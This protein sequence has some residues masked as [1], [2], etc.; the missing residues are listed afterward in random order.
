MALDYARQVCDGEQA[1][2]HYVRIACETFRQDYARAISGEGPWDF[3]ADLV[4][5]AAAFAQALPNIKGPLAGQPL[6]LM[7]WQAL[8][9]AAV[10]GLVERDTDTRRYRQAVVFVGKGNGKTAM[11]A[12]IAL[13]LTFADGEGGAEGYA[14]ATTRD[15]KRGSCSMPHSTCCARRRGLPGGWVSRSQPIPSTLPGPPAG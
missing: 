5:D 13:Y 9:F 3:R 2:C 12:P 7:P 6:Q 8:L 4:D 10:F 15:P 1:V 14:A 11:S